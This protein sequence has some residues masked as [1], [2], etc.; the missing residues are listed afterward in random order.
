VCPLIDKAITLEIQHN[1]RT[2]KHAMF[3]PTV[4]SDAC[5]GC[6]K[7][8]KAC[9]LEEAAI[10][11][12]PV[13]LAKGEMGHHYRLGWEEKKKAGKSLVAPEIDHQYNLPEGFK[14]E[15]GGG[16]TPDVGGESVAPG[17]RPGFPKATHG[18]KL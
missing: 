16:L 14:Y 11:V 6:G 1:Q 5:T 7:C 15:H 9:V 3:L 4:H 17:T 12:F 2:T 18:D 10:R 8:E 13:K